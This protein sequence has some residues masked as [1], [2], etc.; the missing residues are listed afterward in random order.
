MGGSWELLK[1][2]FLVGAGSTYTLGASGGEAT[3]KLTVDE[4]PSHTHTSNAAYAYYG[5]GGSVG[6]IMLWGDGTA[7]VGYTGGGAAHNNMPPFKQV[8]IWER[9]A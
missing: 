5:N 8:Y 3:H 1:D 9:T 6:S 4:M 2:K 7:T